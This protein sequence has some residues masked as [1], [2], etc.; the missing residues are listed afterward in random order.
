MKYLL[1][2]ILLIQVTG[3]YGRVM[4]KFCGTKSILLSQTCCNS[5]TQSFVTGL[6]C[7]IG[8]NQWAGYM[9]NT[10][11]CCNNAVLNYP[12]AA[13]C[14]NACFNPAVSLCCSGKLYSN[15]K[16]PNVACC[17]SVLYN[18]QAAYCC[19]NTVPVYGNGNSPTLCGSS[20]YNPIYQ[21]CCPGS[22]IFDGPCPTTTRTSTIVTTTVSQMP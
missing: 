10:G 2:S 8:N 9:S 22:V 13:L 18:Q 6:C 20:C 17:G 3:N 12:N 19:N 4:R 16:A 21:S 1:I 5:F 7:Q 14:S 11:S 15:L